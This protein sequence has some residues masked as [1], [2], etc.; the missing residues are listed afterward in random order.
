[1]VLGADTMLNYIANGENEI[2]LNISTEPIDQSYKLNL[3]KLGTIEGG[4]YY[5]VKAPN[6]NVIV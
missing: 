6:G 4:G 2:T 5:S 1:M 3:V